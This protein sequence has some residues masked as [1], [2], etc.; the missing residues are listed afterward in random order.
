MEKT[1]P[2]PH[3]LRGITLKAL[4]FGGGASVFIGIGVPYSNMIIKGTVLAHNF[5]TPAALFVFFILLAFLNPFLRQV[6]PSLPLNRAE[7]AVVYIMAMVATSIPTIGFTEYVLPITTGLFYFATPE[8][9]WEELIHPHVPRWIAPQN[10]QAIRYFYEGLPEGMPLPWAAWVEPLAY[11]CLFIL[12]LYW[13]SICTMVILR[14]QWLENEKLLYPLV[15]VPVEMIQGA[16]ANFGRF[17]RNPIMWLGFAVPFVIGNIN[18]L[19]SYYEF[20]P[21]I[22]TFMALHLFRNTTYLRLDINLA[23]IGFGYLLSRDVALGFWLF[24]LLSRLQGGA[25]NFLGIQSTENLSRFANLVGP[26]MA[27]Q[28]MGAMIV[29]VLSGL[30]MARGHLRDVF[31]KAFGRDEGASDAG[32]ILSYRNAVFGLLAGL[33]VMIVWLWQSGIP[34]W[35]VLVLLFAAAIVLIALTRAVVEGGVSVLR[36]PITPADF[37]ISGL[38]TGVLGASGLIGV[39]FTYVWCANVRIFFM[40]CFANGLKMDEEIKGNK[41]GLLWAVLLAIILTL[42]SSIYLVMKMSYAHGGINLHNFFFIFVPKMAF[43]YIAPKFDTP[44]PYSLD[45]WGFTALGAALMSLLTYLRYRFVWW[46]VHPLG[47]ATGTFYIMNWVWFSIFLAWLIKSAILKYSGSGG[48]AR[49][50]PF[51]L[52]LILG[53]VVVAG[54]WL[55]ID[56]FTGM[57]G[58]VIGYL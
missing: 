6:H 55:V 32:E 19:H 4:L 56:Y 1:E 15:Q 44:L 3:R 52:G 31:G 27:H 58:N 8:N 39:A 10:L 28:A 18:A 20:I 21:R 48:Y 24:F 16:D 17:F 42:A 12:A 36:T 51:F 50:R 26:Y 43:T 9:N 30:W 53:Q 37:T 45:G 2:D 35:I 14:R 54:M 47:F 34:L 7:L 38:G 25:F 40:A 29:L 49:T 13:V 46:P 22:E 41:R 33:L 5:S 11:W 57:V 23:L